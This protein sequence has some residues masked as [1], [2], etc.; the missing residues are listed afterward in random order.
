VG[1]QPHRCEGGDRGSGRLSASHECNSR[2]FSRT[3]CDWRERTAGIS[4]RAAPGHTEELP[5]VRWRTPADA[6]ADAELNDAEKL[7]TARW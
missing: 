7:P 1:H 3:K 6:D 4:E 2:G 5:P